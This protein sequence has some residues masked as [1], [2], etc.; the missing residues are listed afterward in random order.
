[1]LLWDMGLIGPCRQSPASVLRPP[2]SWPGTLESRMRRPEGQRALQTALT[3]GAVRTALEP[4]FSLPWAFASDTVASKRKHF[5]LHLA[6]QEF[7]SG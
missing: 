4:L 6:S 2:S 7:I 1:M 5:S 3:A